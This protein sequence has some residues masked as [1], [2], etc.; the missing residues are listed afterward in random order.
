MGAMFIPT[1]LITIMGLSLGV[2]VVLVARE[3]ARR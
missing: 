1:A 3:V 2:I